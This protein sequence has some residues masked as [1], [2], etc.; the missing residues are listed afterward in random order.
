L[1]PA[2]SSSSPFML[3]SPCRSCSLLRIFAAP[4]LFVPFSVTGLFIS[5]SGYQILHS[6]YLPLLSSQLLH[7][8][9]HLLKVSFLSFH[10][11]VSD[12]SENGGHRGLARPGFMGPLLVVLVFGFSCVSVF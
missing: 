9:F 8:Q 1:A 7:H 6:H 10:Y 12:S 3:C 5:L 4:F 11:W 2:P